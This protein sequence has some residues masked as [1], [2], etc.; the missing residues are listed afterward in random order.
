MGGARVSF[1]NGLKSGVNDAL[2]M[3]NQWLTDKYGL[4]DGQLMVHDD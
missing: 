4:T 2:M 1:K 3:V